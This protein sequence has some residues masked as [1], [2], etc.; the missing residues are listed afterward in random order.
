MVLVPGGILLAGAVVE[1]YNIGAGTGTWLGGFSLKWAV[2]FALFTLFCIACL[3][4]LRLAAWPRTRPAAIRLQLAQRRDGRSILRWLLAGALVVTPVWF[5]QYTA[6]GVAIRG[7]YLRV[8]IWCLASVL[9]GYLAPNDGR[10]QP[11]SGFV[12]GALLTGAAFAVAAAFS[13]VTTYPFSLGWSEGNRLWD[14]SLLFGKGLYSYPPSQVPSAYLDIGR[15]LAGG[16]P[17]VLP[18]VSI[19]GERLWL[20]AMGVVPYLL[21]GI[22]AFWDDARSRFGASILAGVWAFLFLS[23]GPIHSP[24]LFCGILVAVARGLPSL[25][26]VVLVAI[27]GYFAEVSRFTWMFAPALWAVMLEIAGS[28]P[29]ESRIPQAAWRRAGL[30]GLAGLA[31]AALGISGGLFRSEASLGSTTAASTDQALL[32]YRLF[33]NATYGAGILLGLALAAGPLLV[34]LVILQ[35][36]S[37]RLSTL[38]QLAI[39][40]PA[41]AFLGVGLIVSTKIGGG[42]DLHNLDMFLIG[43]VFAAAL[44]WK[45][46]ALEQIIEVAR[47]SL[48]A[49]ALLLLMVALPAFPALMTLRPLS[50]GKDAAWLSVLADVERPRDLGSLPTDDVVHS[51]LEQIAAAVK[52]AQLRGDVLFMDQ[53]QLLTFGEI[54]HVELLPAYE[55]KLMMDQALSGNRAYFQ[56][57][58]RDLAAQRFALIVSSPLRT[59]I[60]DSEYGFGEENNAWVRWVAKPILCY[61]EEKDTLNE[62]KVELL[63]P[64]AGPTE[65]STALP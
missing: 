55:K 23:Q 47:S 31:G 9:I 7:P 32:W 52:E 28:T 11:W 60:K 61:Y 45:A 40:L 43:L 58:Y 10:G 34:W 53:R 4:G 57:F 13:G 36:K 14:Y 21:L 22:L 26:A 1:F 39:V 24:L 42:G 15:Q 16:L 44:A 38:R 54:Q 25:T 37:W 5:L 12:V 65:C 62:V 6:W 35:A 46:V 51:S 19:L 27:S 63:A 64:R 59:P 17:F 29:I 50:F 33:P 41:T 18:H 56:G 2:G 30:L 48:W 8:L 3:V 20:A 49:R